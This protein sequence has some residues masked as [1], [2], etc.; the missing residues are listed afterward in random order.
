MLTLGKK[1]EEMCSNLALAIM[2]YSSGC[3]TIWLVAR[4][5][6]ILTVRKVDTYS[7]TYS[8][9][10]V[11]FSI[12]VFSNLELLQKRSIRHAQ[13]N[14]NKITCIEGWILREQTLQMIVTAPLLFNRDLSTL[15][16]ARCMCRKKRIRMDLK[17][18]IAKNRKKILDL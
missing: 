18:V 14:K 1:E 7:V 11:R 2:Q 8:V 13:K 9:C 6:K 16:T 15:Q 17:N 5:K 12:R 10:C 4:S 3:K